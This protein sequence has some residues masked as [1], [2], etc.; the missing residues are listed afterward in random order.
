VAACCGLVQ[1]CQVAGR[2]AVQTGLIGG[3][4]LR[5]ALTTTTTTTTTDAW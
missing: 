1:A 3:D 5:T 2:A 4:T